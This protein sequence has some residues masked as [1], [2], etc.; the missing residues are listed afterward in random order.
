M[1]S[2]ISTETLAPLVVRPDEDRAPYPVA[3]P[4]QNIVFKALGK[5]TGGNFSVGLLQAQPMSGPPLHVHTREDEWFY[6][7]KGEFTFRVGSKRLTAG[8]GTSVFA[9]L[10]VPHTWQNCTNDVAEALIMV[11]P[12]QFEAFFLEAARGQLSP[13]ELEAL[14]NQYGVIQLGPPIAR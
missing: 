3:L 6:V 14:L 2:A 11:T 13:E 9:P 10:D 8:P 5:D 12:P 1:L 4:G 7:L